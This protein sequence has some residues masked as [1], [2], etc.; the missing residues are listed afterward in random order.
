MCLVCNQPD[1]FTVQITEN[2]RVVYDTELLISY[3]PRV[4]ILSYP[5]MKPVNVVF[6]ETSIEFKGYMSPEHPTTQQHISSEKL[7]WDASGIILGIGTLQKLSKEDYVVQDCHLFLPTN[8]KSSNNLPKTVE[9]AIIHYVQSCA[10]ERLCQRIGTLKAEQLQDINR[11]EEYGNNIA[12]VIRLNNP[13]VDLC[14]NIPVDI[15]LKKAINYIK[16]NKKSIIKIPDP[17]ETFNIG[18]GIKCDLSDG[19]FGDFS[20]LKRTGEVVLSNIGRIYT[21]QAEF[22]LSVAKLK[23]NYYKLEVAVIPFSGIIL[24]T[25]DEL[26][27]AVKLVIDYD[28]TCGVNLEYV[29]VTKFGKINLE[30]TGLGPFNNLASNL[31]TWIQQD[32]IIKHIEEYVRNIIEDQLN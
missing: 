8:I 20:T 26:T 19:T 21:I 14:M 3:N 29:K 9:E 28:K 16:R 25:I 10:K 13:R 27:I 31:L 23:Y 15:F 4:G 2:A 32:K 11:Y 30:M 24:G 22:G 12:R 5:E 1:S 6:D 17:I 7:S 18:L